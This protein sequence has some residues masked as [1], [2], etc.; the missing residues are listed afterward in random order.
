MT[1]KDCAQRFC[2]HFAAIIARKWEKSR[3]SSSTSQPF[4]RHCQEK[5]LGLVSLGNSGTILVF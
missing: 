4:V 3:V 5:G 2:I 1:R